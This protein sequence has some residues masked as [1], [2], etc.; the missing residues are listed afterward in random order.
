LFDDTCAIKFGIGRRMKITMKHITSSEQ[1][2]YNEKNNGF[3]QIKSYNNDYNGRQENN[4]NQYNRNGRDS[5]RNGKGNTYNGRDSSDHRNDS[6]GTSLFV[7]GIDTN[8]QEFD[9]H[10]QIK[11]LNLG[12]KQIRVIKDRDSNKLKGF[13]FLEFSSQIMHL[14][15]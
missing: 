14:M 10:K 9:I 13:M 3:D 1:I 2:Q 5:D 4:Y 8:A 11:F 6:T 15:L 7:S 12:E